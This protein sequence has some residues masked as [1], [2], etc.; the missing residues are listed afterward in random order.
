MLVRRTSGV[1]YDLKDA[2]LTF[3]FLFRSIIGNNC[4][5][6]LKNHSNVVLIDDVALLDAYYGAVRCFR[7]MERSTKTFY[8]ILNLRK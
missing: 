5:H 3:L 7:R 1:Y 6:Y 8:C 2:Y 4:F